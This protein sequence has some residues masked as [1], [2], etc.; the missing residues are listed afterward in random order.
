MA[1]YTI[2][3]NDKAYDKLVEKINGYINKKQIEE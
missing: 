1:V 2:F 3:N